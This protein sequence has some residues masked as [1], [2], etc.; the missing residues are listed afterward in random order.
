MRSGPGTGKGF[1]LIELMITVAMVAILVT[2]ALPSYRDHMRT[3]RRAEAQAF[4]M[5]LAARQQQFL[6]DT[7]GYAGALGT[8]AL[9]TPANVEAAYD[10]AVAATVGP[11]PTFL[12]SAT[13]RPDSDQT[14]ERCG[15]L[16]I[17]QSG[18]KSAATNRC[19]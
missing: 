11:P 14:H 3:S 2:V 12:V 8:I 18:A 5:A 13:P 19:W 9:A 10:I 4:L 15:V 1:T 6:I 7:R 17:D 16:S